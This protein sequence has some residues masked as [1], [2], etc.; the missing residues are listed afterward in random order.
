MTC[1]EALELAKQG[2]MVR[3]PERGQDVK[4]DERFGFSGTRPGFQRDAH[5]RIRGRV[6]TVWGSRPRRRC[7]V[8][9]PRA[10]R[11]AGRSDLG[12]RQGFACPATRLYDRCGC[13]TG[14]ATTLASV[15]SKPGASAGRA[16][17]ARRQIR[18]RWP[19]TIVQMLSCIN[20]ANFDHGEPAVKR[21][22]PGEKARS[23][24]GHCHGIRKLLMLG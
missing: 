12:G 2:G 22:P 24:A 13:P 18:R 10:H 17:S 15:R 7:R 9:G 8:R 5:R 14:T 3:L 20:S 1:N 19:A 21:V 4:E 6:R 11:R 23:G 16:R